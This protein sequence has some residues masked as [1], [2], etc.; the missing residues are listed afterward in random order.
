MPN[1]SGLGFLRLYRDTLGMQRK[2][3]PVIFRADDAHEDCV[4][5]AR[6]LGVAEIIMGP[7]ERK[8]IHATL[9]KVGVSA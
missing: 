2:L 1:L 6:E 7:L 9:S 5:E 3:P 4:S 8:H